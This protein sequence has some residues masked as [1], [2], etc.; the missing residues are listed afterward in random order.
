MANDQEVVL[1]RR[2]SE[3]TNVRRA[4]VDVS[5]D[6]GAIL[7][8][9][10]GKVILGTVRQHAL[11]TDRKRSDGG[12]DVGFTSG[13]LLLLAVGSCATG[14]L[15]NYVQREGL[16][17]GSFS[18]GVRYLHRQDERDAIGID[19]RL[20]Q[21]VPAAVRVVLARVAVSGGVGS[22]VAAGSRVEVEVGVAGDDPEAAA[23]DDCAA[24]G[25]CRPSR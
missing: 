12:S 15:R 20:E 10:A 4:V 1:S 11:V 2:P 23:S 21:A 13:E 22:R 14:T 18:V 8:P 9:L 16:E 5:R 19:V 24:G 17:I 7:R 6:E 25:A 3:C